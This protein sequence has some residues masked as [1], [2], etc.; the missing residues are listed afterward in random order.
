MSYKVQ[1][2]ALAKLYPAT[3]TPG[4]GAGVIAVNPGAEEV[5]RVLFE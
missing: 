1:G 4:P 5:K 2:E 3:L